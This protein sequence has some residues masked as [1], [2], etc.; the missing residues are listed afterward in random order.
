MKKEELITIIRSIVKEEV[1]RSLP[2][3]LVEILASKVNDSPMLTET[4]RPSVRPQIPTPAVKRR[5]PMV[6]LEGGFPQKKYSTNPV[7]NQILNE[8]SGG[9]PTEEEVMMN[10][11]SVLDGTPETLNEGQ[12][13][14]VDIIKTR[15]FRSILQAANQKAKAF[16]P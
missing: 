1:E 13:A 6:S 12:S 7:L 16:R 9:I 4:T 11:P 8:T 10:T 5:P 3:V 2:N 15:D 14:V